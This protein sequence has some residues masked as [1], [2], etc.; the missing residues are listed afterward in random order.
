MMHCAGPIRAKLFYNA[1]RDQMS[2][3]RP[4]TRRFFNRVQ[5]HF[6]TLVEV[7]ILGSHHPSKSKTVKITV[8]WICKTMVFTG[9]T[10]KEIV[11]G[12]PGSWVKRIDISGQS[13]SHK[14]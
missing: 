10:L 7:Q 1:I 4:L 6:L 5:H 14:V 13:V 12:F 2:N 11:F 9:N 3:I 8:P